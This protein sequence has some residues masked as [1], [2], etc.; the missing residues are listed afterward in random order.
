[1]LDEDVQDM[2]GGLPLELSEL[3]AKIYDRIVAYQAPSGKAII[4]N[5]LK[6]L[7]CSQGRLTTLEFRKAISMDVNIS[8]ERLSNDHILDLL[9]DFIVLDNGLDIF[10][11]AHLSLREY[12]EENRLE[13]S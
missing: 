1:M 6:W 7:L 5:T 12:S 3:Y 10:R 11:F 9:H 4:Q 13:Y 8:L 2:R